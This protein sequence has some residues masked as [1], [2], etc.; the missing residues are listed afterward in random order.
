[1]VFPSTNQKIPD[2][3]QQLQ[4]PKSY[5]S[6]NPLSGGLGLI[7]EANLAE[8]IQK[9]YLDLEID[10]R[11]KPFRVDNK[12]SLRRD[13]DRYIQLENNEERSRLNDYFTSP[14]V[15]KTKNKKKRKKP[16]NKN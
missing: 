8:G 6:D 7:Q 3:Q 9:N 13:G 11:K 4:V 12:G 15:L 2:G 1:M 5:Q 14:N 16:Q 10:G